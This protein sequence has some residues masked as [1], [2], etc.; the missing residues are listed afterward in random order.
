MG[1]MSPIKFPMLSSETTEYKKGIQIKKNSFYIDILYLNIIGSMGFFFHSFF[2]LEIHLWKKKEEEKS[3]QRHTN[4]YVHTPNEK[5]IINI[6][7]CAG[8]FTCS[9]ILHLWM[10]NS[11]AYNL[12]IFIWNP[13]NHF[14]IFSLFLAMWVFVSLVVVVVVF[15]LCLSLCIYQAHCPMDFTKHIWIHSYWFMAKTKFSVRSFFLCICS[16]SLFSGPQWH[17]F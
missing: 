6:F 10:V 2:R 14:T 5:K 13:I 8:R 4:T 16:F 15:F 12:F 9:F 1:K 17:L 11:S 7:I 3:E